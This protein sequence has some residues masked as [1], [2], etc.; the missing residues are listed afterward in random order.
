D[1]VSSLA[2]Q[3]AVA[4]ENNILIKSIE[5]LFEGFV[6]ASVTAIESRDPTTSGHSFRVADLTVSLAQTVDALSDGKYKEINFTPDEIKEM[7]YAALLHDFGKVGVRENVLV[8]AKKLY[9]MQLELI[10]QRFAYFRKAWESELYKSKLDLLL[11]QGRE[12]YDGRFQEI[13]AI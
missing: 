11:S 10:R 3:A 1:L 13:E 4:L 12:I 2:S 9:P 7:R 5:Q 6:K 8:K